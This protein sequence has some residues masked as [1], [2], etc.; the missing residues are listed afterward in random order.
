MKKVALPNNKYQTPTLRYA[1]LEVSY[2]IMSA[3]HYSYGT[4]DDDIDN[5]TDGGDL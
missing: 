2:G 1:E 3:S 4:K 5:Y